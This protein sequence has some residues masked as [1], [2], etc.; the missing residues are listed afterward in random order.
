M[1][2]IQKNPIANRLMLVSVH[3][4]D[5]E[6]SLI[7]AA[8]AGRSLPRPLVPTYTR[9]H[10][11]LYRSGRNCELTSLSTPCADV[12]RVKGNILVTRDGRACLGDFG[13]VAAFGDL[14]FPRFKL[15]TARYMALERLNLSN[16]PPSAKS[17]IY[18]LAMTSFTVRSPFSCKPN[19][20]VTQPLHH[21]QVLTGVLPYGEVRGHYTLMVRIKSGERPARPTSPDGIRWLQDKVWDMITACW[22]ENE[23][24]RWRISA[25]CNL[26]SAVS[27]LEVQKVKSGN[28]ASN[29][30]NIVVTER[31][32][33]SKQADS[34]ARP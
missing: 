8:I 11:R 23:A 15:G 16:A 10:S 6:S 2:Y 21:H 7:M 9:N 34:N 14:S 24:Q 30:K 3:N 25:I 33:T 26:F 4:V 12:L 19:Q 18:S 22:S 20:A 13:I 27:L 17:D 29:I 28:R 31:S 5:E 32:Q 1:Q